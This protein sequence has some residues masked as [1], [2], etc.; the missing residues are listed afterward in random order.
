[1]KNIFYVSVRVRNF[2]MVCPNIQTR[3]AYNEDLNRIIP[4]PKAF[5]D[6]AKKDENEERKFLL[7][8]I[9]ENENTCP[10][11]IRIEY[12]WHKGITQERE[13]MVKRGL[14]WVRISKRLPMGRSSG[15]RPPTLEEIGEF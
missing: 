15:D 3:R 11:S 1:M 14:L 4:E 2:R 13:I 12:C 10:H 9:A 5:L 6:L 8:W 7:N